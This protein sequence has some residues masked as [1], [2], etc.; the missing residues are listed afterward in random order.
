MTVNIVGDAN[1]FPRLAPC[2]RSPN[3]DYVANAS[4]GAMA[5]DLAD[6]DSGVDGSGVNSEARSVFHNVFEIC[7]LGTQPVCVDFSVDVPAI[8]NGADVPDHYDFEDG[9]LAVVFYRGDNPGEPINVD[10][11]DTD[12]SGAFRLDVGKCQ[13]I[14][15]EIRAFGFESGTDLFE[16]AELEIHAEAGASCGEDESPAPKLVKTWADE[17]NKYD[18]GKRKN[19]SEIDDDRDDPGAALGERDSDFVSLGFGGE[20]IVKFDSEDELVKRGLD[21]DA[22]LVETTNSRDSY[23]EETARVEVAGPNTDYYEIETATSKASGGT[24]TFEIPIEPVN[25]VRITD[26]TDPDEHNGTADGFD[27][28]AVGGWTETS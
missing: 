10:D 22:C 8:P 25:R 13:C 26:T 19:D 9:D 28:R 4:S 7:N 18:P 11:L 1:T 14:G 27:V 21:T 12:R 15:F 16:G 23:L 3:G 24:N 6:G 2:D 20:L 17:V 5:I